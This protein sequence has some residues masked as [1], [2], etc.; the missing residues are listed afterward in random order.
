MKKNVHLS[1]VL[2]ATLLLTAG[3]S[4]EVKAQFDKYKS[5]TKFSRPTSPSIPDTGKSA[6]SLLETPPPAA[7][8]TTNFVT[9]DEESGDD[10]MAEL[11]FN[12]SED[13]KSEVSKHSEIEWSE[14]V[15]RAVR[16]ELGERAKKRIILSAL[17]KLLENSKL[18]DEDCIKLGRKVNEGIYKRYKQ[19]GLL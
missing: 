14:V 3:L 16:R 9:G 12:V 13:V 8:D 6:S 19:E 11:K 17:D 2:T 18:T 4:P 7:G 5:K 10:E 1:Q 15:E